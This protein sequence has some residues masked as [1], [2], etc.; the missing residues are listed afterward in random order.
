MN[1]TMLAKVSSTTKS[2]G[3]NP[4]VDMDVTAYSQGSNMA[5]D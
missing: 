5:T 4:R 2:M 1:S 3:L